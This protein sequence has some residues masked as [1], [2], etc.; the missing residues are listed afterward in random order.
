MVA[1]L[2]R[3]G[4][5]SK[6]IAEAVATDELEGLEDQWADENDG[7]EGVKEEFPFHSV[8][9]LLEQGGQDWKKRNK[10]EKRRETEEA[11]D[12]AKE[13]KKAKRVKRIAGDA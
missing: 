10:I 2:M 8:I 6:S 3:K 11:K 13:E 4:G 12:L 5:M 9:L 7:E 1:H